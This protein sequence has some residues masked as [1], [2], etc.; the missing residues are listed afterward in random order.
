MATKETILRAG[1]V[2][3]RKHGLYTMIRRQVA[4]AAKVSPA[5]VS[6]YFGN[7]SELRTAVIKES[8]V[9]AQFLDVLAEALGRRDYHALRAPA[10]VKRAALATIA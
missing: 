10:E 2:A 7:M 4:K 9:R 6:H 1:L 3:A 5:L 8:I